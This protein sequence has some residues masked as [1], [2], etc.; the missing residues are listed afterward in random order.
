MVSGALTRASAPTPDTFFFRGVTRPLHA[1]ARVGSAVFR[2]VR[3]EMVRHDGMQ[4]DPDEELV[5]RVRAG[6]D[7]ACVELLNRYAG[8]ARARATTYYLAGADRE[9][10]L[11]EA[12]IGLYKAIRDFDPARRVPFAAFADLCVT[13]Q[14]ISAVQA[15]SRHKHG[16][17]NDYVPIVGL[18]ADRED[19]L[20][21]LST[22]RYDDPVQAVL[23]AEWVEQL[24]RYVDE[25]LTELEVQVLRL[26]LDG[27]SYADIAVALQRH[28]KTVDNALQRVKRKLGSHLRAYDM[29]EAC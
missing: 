28:G 5:R 2:T 9:D 10:L 1:F 19:H 29:V 6:S 20:L 3:L 13:R 24:Q 8:V 11:Q 27:H 7:S 14:V 16:P 25:T 12:R 26:H 21:R 4:G 17:L 15:A 23:L 22:R 18:D